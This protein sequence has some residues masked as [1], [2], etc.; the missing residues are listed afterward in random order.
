MPTDVL[1]DLLKSTQEKELFNLLTAGV[2]LED[3]SRE[4][5]EIKNGVSRT[6]SSIL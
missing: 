3:D 2:C 6:D 5:I 4:D 1:F